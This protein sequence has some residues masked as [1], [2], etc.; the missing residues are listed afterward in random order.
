MSGVTAVALRRFLFKDGC[1]Y[2][3]N[4]DNHKPRKLYFCSQ[5]FGLLSLY[6]ALTGIDKR[7]V[8]KPGV[9]KPFGPA[10]VWAAFGRYI[11]F[12]IKPN[13]FIPNGL[14]VFKA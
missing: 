9:I 13:S 1:E 5:L 6:L 8:I 7:G 2:T 10:C 12:S 11:E 14:A 4:N 3:H